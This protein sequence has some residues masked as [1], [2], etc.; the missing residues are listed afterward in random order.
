M[1]DLFPSLYNKTLQPDNV[2]SWKLEWAAE[3]NEI[4]TESVRDLHLIL[5]EVQPR[6]DVCDRRRW[7][8][9]NVGSF[10][11]KSAYKELLNR[12]GAMDLELDPNV[13]ATRSGVMQSSTET[14]TDIEY[15]TDML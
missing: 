5:Q 14:F 6:L 15:D 11:V 3:L 7:K 4:E 8:L 2:V 13:A 9:N 12:Y 10:S 1:R